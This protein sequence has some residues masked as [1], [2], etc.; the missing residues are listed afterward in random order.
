MK[1]LVGTVVAL[2]VIAAGGYWYLFSGEGEEEATIEA[3]AQAAAEAQAD[4]DQTASDDSASDDSASEESASDE[5]AP[6]AS[7][8][9]VWTAQANDDATFV[10]YRINE[11]L[12]T[13]GDFEVVGRT[14]EVSGTLTITGTTVESVELT[15]QMDSL[16]TDNGARDSAMRS[17]ALE[18]NEFPTATFVLTSPIELG[19][20]PAERETIA[21]TATGDLTIHGVTQRVDFPL[22]AQLVGQSIV[23][24]GQL[25]VEL[26]D[27]DIAAPQARVV[28]SVE[29]VALLELS[30]LFDR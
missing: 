5:P 13:I 10:G 15:A 22:E 7:V 3:A 4:T 16:T 29:D 21:I 1:I 8:E 27:Y 17:Q 25:Q 24:V 20:I 14:R 19:A 2:A 18:T 30:V 12:T 23:V 6:P 9:G 28:A 11:V 26:A